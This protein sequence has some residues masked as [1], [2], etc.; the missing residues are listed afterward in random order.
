MSYANCP[1]CKTNIDLTLS[2]P[3]IDYQE[4]EKVMLDQLTCPECKVPFLLKVT[5]TIK[6]KIE[7]YRMPK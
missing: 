7:S 2:F 6:D 1:H 5:R 4:G 3:Y